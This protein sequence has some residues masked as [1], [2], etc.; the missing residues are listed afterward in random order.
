[1]NKRIH[2]KFHKKYIADIVYE[3]SISSYWRDQLLNKDIS[4][5]L[6]IDKNNM[7]DLSEQTAKII[8]ANKLSYVV[9]L[10]KEY[11]GIEKRFIFHA[12]NYKVVH[13][14]SYNNPNVI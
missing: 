8:V 6:S 14:D 3:V 2:K 1:M 10:D 4:E 5:Q 13:A 11:E 9:Y 12:Q 7:Q